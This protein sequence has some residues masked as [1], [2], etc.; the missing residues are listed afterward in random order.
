MH[1]QCRAN[2][3]Q[4][5][6]W[7]SC[8]P[9][10]LHLRVA[11]LQCQHATSSDVQV[12]LQGWNHP[13]RNSLKC[14]QL[15]STDQ[16]RP[17]QAMA[18]ATLNIWIRL[19]ND[20]NAEEPNELTSSA[21]SKHRKDPKS[22]CVWNASPFTLFFPK[23]L[24]TIARGQE[25][26]FPLGLQQLV[27]SFRSWRTCPRHKGLLQTCNKAQASNIMGRLLN[28][29]FFWTL[30]YQDVIKCVIRGKHSNT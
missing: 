6:Q 27:R 13:S 9:R 22:E 21:L 2:E 10:P 29:V 12:S 18:T 17:A 1:H 4:F 23:K 16:N 28:V 25:Q 24:C 14:L 19:K 3:Q 20:E 5:L 11:D 26:I 30:C 8:V 7:R 15:P